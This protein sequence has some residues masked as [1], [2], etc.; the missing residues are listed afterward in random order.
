MT[1][2]K[3][4]PFFFH[5]ISCAPSIL[6]IQILVH[7]E[8]TVVIFSRFPSLSPLPLFPSF[9]LSLLGLPPSSLSLSLCLCLGGGGGGYSGY[10]FL[11]LRNEP[12]VLTRKPIHLLSV[13][14]FTLLKSYNYNADKR[15]DILLIL[16]SK[17]KMLSDSQNSSRGGGGGTT[18]CR[19]LDNKN[20][21]K[22]PLLKKKFEPRLCASLVLFMINNI[23]RV[24]LPDCGIQT[25]SAGPANP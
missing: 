12:V 13:Q 1:H 4:Y 14:S 24:R 2:K 19:S 10:A 3:G 6:C 5:P 25:G 16:F 11:E 23:T 7:Y 18:P 21:R 22:C 20:K 8:W 15:I 9:P 17:K